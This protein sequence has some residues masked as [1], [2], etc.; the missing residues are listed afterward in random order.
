MTSIRR[1]TNDVHLDMILSKTY[2]NAT[3]LLSWL[4]TTDRVCT[5]YLMLLEVGTVHQ[6]RRVCQALNPQ[7]EWS[8][9]KHRVRALVLKVQ[10]KLADYAWYERRLLCQRSAA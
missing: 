8:E 6:L 3:A 7:T 5:E 2:P 4:V 1:M 9:A 10:P